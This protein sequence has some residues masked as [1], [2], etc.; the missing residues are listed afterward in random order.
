[1]CRFDF[2]HAHTHPISLLTDELKDIETQA[3]DQASRVISRSKQKQELEQ[4]QFE[5]RHAELT[6]STVELD[7]SLMEARVRHRDEEQ[8]L[9]KRRGRVENELE[10]WILKFD[11]EMTEKQTE[12]DELQVGGV[13]ERICA[14]RVTHDFCRPSTGKKKKIFMKSWSNTKQ[15]Q[16]SGKLLPMNDSERKMQSKYSLKSVY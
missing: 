16:P 9:R 1:M 12:F 2:E 11:T 5:F 13:M 8:Q 14:L 10:A 7:R 4:Q 3:E 15:S 6:G